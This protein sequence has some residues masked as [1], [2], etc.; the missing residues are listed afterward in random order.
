M[1]RAK[2][3]IIGALFLVLCSF[4]FG[5]FFGYSIGTDPALESSLVLCNSRH[6]LDLRIAEAA[7]T[8]YASAVS[9]LGLCALALQQCDSQRDQIAESYKLVVTETELEVH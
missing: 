6:A 4:C 5:A 7:V 1:W 3:G 9:T 8:N 2:Q